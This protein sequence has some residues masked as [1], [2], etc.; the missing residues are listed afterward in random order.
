MFATHDRK[1][2]ASV[3]KIQNPI[4]KCVMT[5][6]KYKSGRREKEAHGGRIDLQSNHKFKY[7]KQLLISTSRD[8]Q[9][10]CEE[11]FYRSKNKKINSA[12]VVG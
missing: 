6:N 3:E 11:M 1:A 7:L 5:R 2:F 12:D 4:N 10:L 9:A 8:P